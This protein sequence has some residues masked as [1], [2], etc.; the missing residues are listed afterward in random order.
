M[1]RIATRPDLHDLDAA[2]PHVR[3]RVLAQGCA[4]L[5][6]PVG[7]RHDQHLDRS[8]ASPIVDVP[9]HVADD[10]ALDLDH[11]DVLVVLGVVQA[12]HQLGVVGPPSAVVVGED[13]VAD[14]AAEGLLENG[15]KVSTV[16]S[17]NRPMSSGWKGRISVECA[18]RKRVSYRNCHQDDERRVPHTGRPAFRLVTLAVA[19]GFEPTEACTSHA[20]EACSFGRSDTLPPKTLQ[21]GRG[22]PTVG[23][24]HAN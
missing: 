13:G 2:G 22:G 19:V 23:R 11:G 5:P 7:G 3:E 6:T 1:E 18:A 15:S 17:T 10:V 14:G 20:F 12:G 21:D 4:E 16:S 24:G 8:V 9:G